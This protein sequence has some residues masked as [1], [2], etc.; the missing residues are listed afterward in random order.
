MEREPA[1]SDVETRQDVKDALHGD[2]RVDSRRITVDV[3][4][5]VVHLHGTVPSPQQ[6]AWA[7]QIAVRIKGV[8]E[9]HNELAVEPP[10]QRGDVDITADVAAALAADSLVDEDKI[11]VT[12]VDSVVY[13]RGVVESYVARRVAE[14][15]ARGI[16]GVLDVIDEILVSPSI[17]RS[18]EEIAHAAWQE[19]HRN[20]RLPPDAVDVEVVHGIARLRGRV[21]TVTQRWLADEIARWTPGVVD[22]IN[23]LANP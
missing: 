5:G 9:V 18:D 3:R 16:P 7:R 15:D 17:A 4:D 8:R 11:E 23:E 10:A 1:R 20:L 6:K 13:L 22:V 2:V 12:T 21:E 14:E 19:I